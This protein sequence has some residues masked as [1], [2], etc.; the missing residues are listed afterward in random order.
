MKEWARELFDSPEWRASA[1]ERI[2]AGKAPHL[3][4]HV[5]QVLMPKV[6]HVNATVSKTIEDI[7]S[8]V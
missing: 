8:G 2:V 6:D 4:A 7:V 5:L 3:E 1:R